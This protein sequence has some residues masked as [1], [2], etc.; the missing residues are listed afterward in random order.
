[1][2]EALHGGFPDPWRRPP[3]WLGERGREE[4][5]RVLRKLAAMRGVRPPLDRARLIEHCE[6]VD[7]GDH[8]AASKLVFAFNW[9][10]RGNRPKPQPGRPRLVVDNTDD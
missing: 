3:A 1:M 2:A 9:F 6:A 8:A 5:Q 10:E 4:Y 7:R